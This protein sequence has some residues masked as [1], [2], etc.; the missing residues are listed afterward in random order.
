MDPSYLQD[1]QIVNATLGDDAGLLG[2]L[3][4]ALLSGK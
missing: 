1:L 3:S 4:L 2:A